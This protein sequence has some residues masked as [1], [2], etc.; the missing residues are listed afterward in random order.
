[1][2]LTAKQLTAAC[3]KNDFIIVRHIDG[4][5]SALNCKISSLRRFDMV[6]LGDGFTKYIGWKRCSFQEYISL[7]TPFISS[8]PKP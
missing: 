2:Y 4:Y 5:T 6:R 1:M 7:K 8:N 3:E